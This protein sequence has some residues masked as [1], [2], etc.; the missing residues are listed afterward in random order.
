MD[1]Q[2]AFQSCL[3]SIAKS[4]SRSYV[5]LML[6][7]QSYAGAE[8]GGWYAT[9]RTLIRYAEF[10]SPEAAA[11]AAKCVTELANGLTRDAE[12]EFNRGCLASLV[13]ADERGVDYDTLPEVGGADRYY[14]IVTDSLPEKFEAESRHYE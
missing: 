12:T 13:A 3:G 4:P 2:D 1:I 11:D 6:A 10:S 14:V 5:C 8:E 9:D 7:E